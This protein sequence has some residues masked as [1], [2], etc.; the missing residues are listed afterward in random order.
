M[1][2]NGSLQ[3]SLFYII[4]NDSLPMIFFII[5]SFIINYLID[6]FANNNNNNI[7]EDD[8]GSNNS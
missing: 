5:T 8:D 6:T 1:K 4:Y 2:G 7:M 3:S